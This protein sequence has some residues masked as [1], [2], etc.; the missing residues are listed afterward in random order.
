MMGDVGTGLTL[1]AGYMLVSPW[2]PLIMLLPIIGWAWMISSILDKHAA[3]FYL[4]RET[5]GLVHLIAGLAGVLAVVLMPVPGW[6]GFAAGLLVMIAIYALDI[7][8]FVAMANRDERVP[9][10]ARLSLDFSKWKEARAAKRGEKSMGTSKLRINSPSKAGIAVP[11]KGTPEYELRVAAEEVLLRGREIRA[12]QID[13]MPVGEKQYA[14]SFMVDGVRQQGEPMPPQQAV[15]IIDFWKKCGELDVNDRRRKQTATITVTADEVSTPIRLT[16]SGSQAGMKLTLQFDPA[17][18][19]RRGLKDLGLLDAQLAE[20]RKLI[21]DGTG[22]V[23]LAAPSDN[24]RTTTMYA[25]LKQHDAYTSNV[26][27]LEF[28]VDDA[29]EGVRQNV[30]ES[31]KENADYATQLRSML[32]RDPD[33]VGSA[34]VPDVQTAQEISKADLERTRVYAS[35]RADGATAALQIW[36]RAVGDPKTAAKA[37]RGVIAHRLVRKLCENCRVAYTPPPDMLKKLGLPADKVKQLHKKGGQVLV[38]SKPET[39]PVCNGIGYFGQIGVFEVLPIGPEEQALIAKE[40][41]S[42]LRAEMR[43]KQM[44]SLAQV[45][46]RRAVEGVTSVEEVTRV[47]APAKKK[48]SGGSERKAS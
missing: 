37:L 10:H 18:S 15:S 2:Q 47:T 45:A 6:G 26:Q 31:T 11:E 28:E 20:V 34:E 16:T 38:R 29:I 22:T 9:E 40:N 33:V 7:G 35:I 17:A 8:L 39:C 13:L 14:A 30:F 21:E 12:S 25:L 42:G 44:P 1:G 5:W 48:P 27:T 41:W 24:G 46:L 32:R 4:G 23:L 3:R 36:S 43:K 19:V